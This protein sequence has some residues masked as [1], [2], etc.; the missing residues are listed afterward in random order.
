MSRTD[1]LG[2]FEVVRVF[3]AVGPAGV[4]D[5]EGGREFVLL[6]KIKK[7][8]SFL[9]LQ[10]LQFGALYYIPVLFRFLSFA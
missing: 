7:C 9:L 4:S 5:V 10:T 1:F 3:V 2:N 6:D 8:V